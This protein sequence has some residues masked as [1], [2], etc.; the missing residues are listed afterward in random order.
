MTRVVVIGAGQA[1]IGVTEALRA[2]GS[3]AQITVVGGEDELPY[4]RPPL[5]KDVLLGKVTVDGVRLRSRDWYRTHDVDL[6]LSTWVE[7]IDRD[8][9][10]V[11][12]DDGRTLEYDHLVLAT[13]SRPRRL[14][15]P[16]ADLDGVLN[17][18]TPSDSAQ[19]RDRLS[20]ARDVVV[21]GAGF[22]GLEVAAAVTASGLRPVVVELADRVLARVAGPVLSAHVAARHVDR[23]VDLRLGTGVTELRGTEGQ[24]THV[25]TSTGEV[26][27]ADLVVVGVGSVPADGLA[28]DAGLDCRD[29]VVVDET[30]RTSDPAI[31]AIGDCCRF[32]LGDQPTRLE[33]VQNAT[34]QARHV[35]ARLASAAPFWAPYR[36]VPWFWSTQG[37]LKLQMVGVP[38]SQ[39]DEVVRGD[40]GG[41]RFSVFRYSGDDL[42]CVESV[43]HAPGHLIGRRLLASGHSPTREQAADPGFDLK[44]FAAA[45]QPPTRTHESAVTW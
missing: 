6:R 44:A 25:V 10:T 7:R 42:T 20:R 31:S 41:G 28:A 35:A 33:S 24:V 40:P 8:S 15:V 38:E 36:E 22:I 1:G 14:P 45:A 5:S 39:D 27:P 18:A 30:L 37:D 16:G 13:G 26:I 4:E 19:L 34:D 11:L 3:S 32:P 21:I 29:G 23:G 9:R 12:L 2:K 17:L 43:N